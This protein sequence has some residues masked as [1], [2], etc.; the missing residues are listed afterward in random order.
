MRR[1]RRALLGATIAMSGAAA[2]ACAVP[3]IG[4]SG[5]P[6]PLGEHAP[7]VLEF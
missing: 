2:A 1:T 4:G 3:L 7:M 6:R 5:A